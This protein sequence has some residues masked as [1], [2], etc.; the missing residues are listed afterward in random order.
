[1]KKKALPILN[2]AQISCTRNNL[3]TKLP[4]SRPQLLVVKKRVN[5]LLSNQSFPSPNE[6][7]K[8]RLIAHKPKK[9]G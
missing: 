5:P 6:T 7:A 9:S 1:M 4:F 2:F 8:P 3:E